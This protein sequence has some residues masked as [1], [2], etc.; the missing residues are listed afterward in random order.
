[1]INT[2]LQ[3]PHRSAYMYVKCCLR[4]RGGGGGGGRGRLDTSLPRI[5]WREVNGVPLYGCISRKV[6]TCMGVFV[7]NLQ[8]YGCNL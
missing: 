5:A 4:E 1:M 2:R 8:L 7:D 6:Y 3:V